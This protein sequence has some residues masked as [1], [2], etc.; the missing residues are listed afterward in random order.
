MGI[1][2]AI[3]LGMAGQRFGDPGGALRH[4]AHTQGKGFEPLDQNPGIKGTQRCPCLA[5]QRVHI[6]FDQ[7]LGAQH[8]AAQHPALPIDMLGG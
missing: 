7:L 5:Q 6:A 3:D 1:N 2:H 4:L 8:N